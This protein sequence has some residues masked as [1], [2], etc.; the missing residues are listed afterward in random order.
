MRDKIPG[1][2]RPSFMLNAVAKIPKG[3]AP[4]P[5]DIWKPPSPKPKPWKPCR[6]YKIRNI[7][8]HCQIAK[9]EIKHSL[10][11]YLFISLFI[12]ACWKLNVC[13]EEICK[14][15]IS[16]ICKTGPI[17]NFIPRENTETACCCKVNPL[18]S[19]RYP[20]KA[21]KI[22]NTYAISLFKTKGQCL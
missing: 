11:F 3:K 21:F 16:Q 1:G 7:V 8:G 5:K 13:A 6:E 4:I 14:A 19:P 12:Y 10:F 9:P 2:G 17:M 18:L 22:Q 20:I 15:K